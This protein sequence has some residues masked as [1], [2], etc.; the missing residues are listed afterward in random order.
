MRFDGE[1]YV[2]H[3]WC[4]MPNHVQVLFT[5]QAGHDLGGITHSMNR[6]INQEDVRSTSRVL[7][8]VGPV[9]TH[10]DSLRGAA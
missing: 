10:R 2:L 9:G 4:V 8:L 6:G 5:A 3:A 7:L 1:R